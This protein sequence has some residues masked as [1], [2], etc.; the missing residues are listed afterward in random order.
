M[1]WIIIFKMILHFVNLSK[2]R[3][4]PSIVVY[5]IFNASNLRAI[6]LIEDVLNNLL[7]DHN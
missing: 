3:I 6:K 2:S 4:L 7:K 5:I 1:S